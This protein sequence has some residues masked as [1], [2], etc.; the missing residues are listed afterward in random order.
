MKST[1]GKSK[2]KVIALSLCL[3]LC[4]FPGCGKKETMQDKV[5]GLETTESIAAREEFSDDVSFP[6][7]YENTIEN[8][9]FNMDITVDADL[10]E[11]TPV[12]AKA[13][14]KKR[15]QDRLLTCCLA[16]RIPMKHM[17]MKKR[18]SMGKK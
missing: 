16:M 5:Q 11:E 14:M 1:K 17:S 18:M 3:L 9:R 4:S 10:S 12:M 2:R 8:V 15:M 7:R 13:R 6:A